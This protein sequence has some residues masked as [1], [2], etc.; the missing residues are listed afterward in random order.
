MPTDRILVGLLLAATLTASGCSSIRQKPGFDDVQGLVAQRSDSEVYWNTGSDADRDVEAR[1]SMLLQQ[2]ITADAAVQIALLN[3]RSLQATYQDL[4]VAQADLVQ[5]GL[6]QN[7][8]L[9]FERRFSGKAM[10][11]DVAQ[12]FIDL[13]FLP[14]RKRT[15]QSEFEAAKLRV[16]Q[17]ILDHA[18][19]VRAAFYIM[20]ASI[21]MAELRRSVLDAEEAASSA[22]KRLYD[23]GNITELA[24]RDEQTALAEAKVELAVAEAET[25]QARE[26]LNSL[27]GLWGQAT[28][29]TAS[30]RLPV[31]PHRELSGS[32]LESVAVA[33]R[34]DL[35]AARQEILT[36]AN[37]L[38]LTNAV[39][40]L[41]DLELTSHVEREP[42]GRTTTGPS[43]R[44]T[45]PIFDQGQARSARDRAFLQQARERYFALAVE[46]R[47]QVRAA[48]SRLR[49]AQQKAEFYSGAL[50]PLRALVLRQTQ[51]Q[52]N[53]MQVGVFELLTAKRRQI[54]SARSGI[55][56]Q[57]DYWIARTDLERALG[58]KLS[59]E[60]PPAMLNSTPNAGEKL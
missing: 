16:A 10:E 33:Q 48:Y 58:G 36:R 22:A 2:E 40:F 6:L 5:A 59:Q 31:L 19:E 47:S 42:D 7:P 37:S 12:N 39:R 11:I 13:F 17:A 18:A 52:Y 27:M 24:W 28:G 34:L 44:L 53:A 38:G 8:V 15:A 41:P 49:A 1:V 30:A 45:L 14:L 32:S 43:V 54:E 51:L 21:Q 29:W 20:Q 3:N 26:R 50:L 60:S 4:G 46:I 55:E 56:A 35:L 23:A 25:T 9:S 57:R